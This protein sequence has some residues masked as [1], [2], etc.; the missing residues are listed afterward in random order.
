MELRQVSGLAR[1][2]D[3]DHPTNRW[4][5]AL[6]LV[7]LISGTLIA[8]LAGQGWLAA[9]GWS[10][11]AALAFF[12]A[13]ALARE[14]DPDA[15]LAAFVAAGFTLPALAAA[16]LGWL[17]L[18]DLAALFLILLALRVVNRTTGLAATLPDTVG[19]LGLGLWLGYE[20]N[21]IYLALAVA[22]LLIDGLLGRP[23]IRRLLL[24]GG[25]ALVGV[26]LLSFT[27]APLS[28][29]LLARALAPVALLAGLLI[30]A[31][32]A[33]VI[34]AAGQIQSHT[35]D[36]DEPLSSR[37]VRAGQG[38]ALLTGLGLT[39]WHGY[40]GLFGL[41]PLWAAMAGTGASRLVAKR[42]PPATE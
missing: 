38:L 3:L 42:K 4:I 29:S 13:W 32:F 24:A 6:T 12:L 20:A 39:L 5:G 40:A 27:D 1:P 25:A 7:I 21:P 14:L 33:T 34:R 36:T 17:P 31:L 28:D 23:D 19:V 22:A 10:A 18:P 41:L 35:D 30:A 26:L 9:I 16:G 15:E 2:I 37:R 8:A 11:L